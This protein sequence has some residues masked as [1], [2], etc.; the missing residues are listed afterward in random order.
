MKA[1]GDLLK[2]P[3]DQFQSRSYTG[4]K[5]LELL[6]LTPDGWTQLPKSTR[7][8]QAVNMREPISLLTDKDTARSKMNAKQRTLLLSKDTVQSRQMT[9]I[10]LLPR[11]K[12]RAEPLK[13]RFEDRSLRAVN[14]AQGLRSADLQQFLSKNMEHSMNRCESL[15]PRPDGV[16]HFRRNRDTVDLRSKGEG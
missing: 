7:L 13:S 5:I 3:R 10:H 11:N 1:E 16:A 8:A 2:K 4:L 12:R 9:D 6:F 14:L 15:C